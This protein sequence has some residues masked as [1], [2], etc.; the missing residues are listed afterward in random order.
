MMTNFSEI[1]AS[2]DSALSASFHQF[3]MKL[4]TL[5]ASTLL[6]VAV[7]SSSTPPAAFPASGNGLWYNSTGD[8]TGTLWSTTFLPIG[9]GY[10]A[11]LWFNPLG[12]SEADEVHLVYSYDSRRNGDRSSSVEH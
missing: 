7:I 11:G 3:I 2:S 1:L 6:P 9:N 12:C 8:V 10:L 5:T 4:K